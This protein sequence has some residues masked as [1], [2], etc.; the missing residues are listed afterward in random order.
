M[1]VEQRGRKQ[2]EPEGC[3]L[4]PRLSPDGTLSVPKAKARR[5]AGYEERAKPPWTRH[6]LADD[7]ESA[8]GMPDC[9]THTGRSAPQFTP[10]TESMV[11]ALYLVSRDVLS[12]PLLKGQKF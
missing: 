2:T 4:L 12:V 8:L 1:S 10:P 5:D 9:S 7:I 3:Q 11:C 6:P